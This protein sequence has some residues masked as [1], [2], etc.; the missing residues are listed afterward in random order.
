MITT[1]AISGYRSLRDVIVPLERLN[2]VTGPNGAG[3]SNLYKA[4]RLLANIAHGHIVRTI[5]HEGGFGSTLWA[6]PEQFSRAMKAGTQPIQ[7]TV[8]DKS[9][10]LKLGF[11]T[12]DYGY[13]I[14][15]GLPVLGSSP[16][17]GD[18]HLKAESL[19]VGQVLL[20]RNEIASRKGPR[21]RVVR[22]AGVNLLAEFCCVF[23]CQNDTPKGI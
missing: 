11:A 15:L 17:P 6:G 3:K 7:G 4:L 2:V 20:P 21:R 12:D 10:A 5:A 23:V 1:L 9:V 18:P 16:F 13:A 19:W 14:D 8:R 22:F